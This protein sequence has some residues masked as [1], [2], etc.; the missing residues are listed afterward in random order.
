MNYNRQKIAAALIAGVLLG[1]CSAVAA[2]VASEFT[3]GIVGFVA[4]VAGVPQMGAT[5]LLF[6]RYD[7]L[8]QKALTNEKGAFGF[9]GISPDLYSV[10]VTLSSFVPAVKRNLTIQPGVR[11]FLSISLASVFSSIELVN[12]VPGQGAIMSDDWKW[13][14]RSSLAT[15]PV[16]RVLPS[17]VDISDPLG[18]HQNV[19]S[20]T[21]GMLR[22]SAGDNG[23]ASAFSSEPDLGTAFALATSLYG[24][25]QI[26][27]AG[28]FGYAAQVGTPTAGFRTS[29]APNISGAAG[30]EVNLTMRQ[31]FLPLRAGASYFSAQRDG[32][33][34]LTS[35]SLSVSEKRKIGD[36]IELAYGL[37]LE[38]VS[39]LDRLN[40]LSPYIQLSYSLGALGTVMA[41]YSSGVPPTEAIVPGSQSEPEF[42]REL[43]A[44]SAFPR[45][46]RRDGGV[47]VQRAEDFELSYRK[48]FGSRTLSVGA[49]RESVS[50][51]ALTLQAPAGTYSADNLLAD[52]FTN[53]SILNIGTVQRT[54]VSAAITQNWG[55]HFSVTVAVGNRGVLT[56]SDR[57]LET[58]DSRE[59]RSVLS[60]GQQSWASAQIA[61][62]SPWG[63]TK[64]MSSY[65][66]D[67]YSAVAPVHRSLT[68]RMNTDPGLNLQIRQPLGNVPGFSG[69]LEASAE[70]RNLMA[71]GYVPLSTP[72][73]GRLV[74]V[75]APRSVR[76]TISF[77]F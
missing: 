61:G 64:F 12:T 4:D 6:N 24:S 7:R 70:L 31:T 48:A 44:L 23:N 72:D 66:W 26:Q 1:A 36:D 40:F 11:S 37:S 57:S 58:S 52:P 63:G 35:M 27:F 17:G 47:R 51:A 65:Q 15:R 46:S 9:D 75:Q 49:Y 59:L 55:D 33:P 60:P 71:Q 39:F 67:D 21:R 22:V 18:Q 45:I 38:S 77:I 50:N 56:V 20:G 54:G 34:G 8:I 73:G 5:V 28:N 14:L 69:R 68:Q 32:S 42:G 2:P 74:L 30:P 41:G 43:A 76:G 19:F 16:L 29:F 62:V 53:S 13:V 3:G 10:R 25:N